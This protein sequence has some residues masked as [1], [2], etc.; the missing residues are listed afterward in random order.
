VFD[1]RTSSIKDILVIQLTKMGDFLQTTP[2]LYGIKQ[3]YPR[4]NLAVMTDTRCVEIASDVSFI[5]EVIPLGLTSLHRKINDSQCSIFEKYSYL[6][7]QLSSLEM[8]HFDI[9]YNINF[10]KITAILCQLFRNS[11]V[12]GYRLDPK[13]HR[14]IKEPWVSFIFHL[15]RHRNML[16]FNLVDL[17][18]SYENGDHGPSP[19]LFFQTNGAESPPVELMTTRDI[20]VIGLQMGCGG[21]LRRWPMENFADLAYKLVKDLGAKVVLFGT[22]AERDLGEQFENEWCR[23]AGNRPRED[24]VID[25]MGK[26]NISQLAVSLEKC[27]LLITGDTGT[28][29]LATAMGTKVLALFMATAL[30]HETGPYGEG[31]YVMQAHM[32]CSPCTEG[33]STCQRP[34]C[35][36]LI[37]PEM[38]Y[39]LVSHMLQAKNG[40]NIN[41][42]TFSA[43]LD[44]VCRDS[45]CGYPVLDRD[46]PCPYDKLNMDRDKP[47]PYDNKKSNGNYVQIYR[48]RMD[49]WGVKFLP[50]VE[51]ELDIEE[52][53]AMAYRELGRKLMRPSYQIN[54]RDII[55]ELSSHYR[56]IT[57]DTREK[58]SMVFRNLSS[59]H[60]ICKLGAG[61]SPSLSLSD[62]QMKIQESCG[63]LD[64]L[65]PLA[66]YFRDLKTETELSSEAGDRNATREACKAMMIPV[67]E[68]LELIKA[69]S[70]FT[71]HRLPFTEKQGAM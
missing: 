19:G 23:I 32:P 53:M 62:V 41:D 6:A 64:V 9:I 55:R 21:D 8:R 50:L 11:N 31:H 5:D 60:S 12:I 36:R 56:D 34:V 18:A 42:F 37:H 54:F 2:L 24:D 59:L 14:V 49:D 47:C 43:C 27:N 67:K 63:S 38:V 51:R 44:G 33:E 57:A 13:T 17:L 65:A 40:G 52:I 58:V 1:M 3:K 46:E 22:K 70:L 39:G 35:Q 71:V 26:T 29:Q 66:G 16:R 28:M 25:L 69:I 7:Q 4:A 15:M 61:K 20:P 45:P 68:L 48:T 30:C 10:S